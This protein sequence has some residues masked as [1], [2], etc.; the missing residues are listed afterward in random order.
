MWSLEMIQMET[1][2]ALVGDLHVSSQVVQCMHADTQ[3]KQ[4]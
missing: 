2:M 1:G 4:I 3:A